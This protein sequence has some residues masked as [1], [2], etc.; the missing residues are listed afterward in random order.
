MDFLNYAICH[1]T[2]YMKSMADDQSRSG[3]FIEA[4]TAD[5]VKQKRMR[6]WDIRR[7]VKYGRKVVRKD[8]P[9]D[10]CTR[11]NSMGRR[12]QSGFC[13][14]AILKKLTTS[15]SKVSDGHLSFPV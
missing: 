6:Q 1:F 5:F 12:S 10:R 14:G 3:T 13:N 9:A 7:A 11:V 4:Y 2:Y 8:C 15:S